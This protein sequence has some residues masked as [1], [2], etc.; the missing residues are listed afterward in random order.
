MRNHYRLFAPITVLALSFFVACG[1]DKQSKHAEPDPQAEIS[2]DVTPVEGQPAVEGQDPQTAQ[3]QVVEAGAPLD[4]ATANIQVSQGPISYGPYPY[5]N[6]PIP[7]GYSYPGTPGYENSGRNS[8]KIRFVKEIIAK[9]GDILDLPS[10]EIPIDYLP[11]TSE[12][13]RNSQNQ[14]VVPAGSKITGN[15]IVRE[16]GQSVFNGDKFLVRGQQIPFTGSAFIPS[17]VAKAE[18]DA[19]GNFL[20]FTLGGTLLAVLIS[21]LVDNKKI[22]TDKVLIGSGVG[23]AIGTARHYLRDD[24]VVSVGGASSGAISNMCLSNSLSSCS[25]Y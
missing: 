4:D 10:K 16:N 11:E 18:Y 17:T 24:E 1:D 2:I 14:L 21:G 8:V 12:D 15:I 5:S 25:R 7:Q 6:G 3:T 19:V 20:G 22:T 13:I 23:L 9:D